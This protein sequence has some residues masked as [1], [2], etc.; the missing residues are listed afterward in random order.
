MKIRSFT[1]AAVALT[2]GLLCISAGCATK[3]PTAFESK[4]F[5]IQTN[6]VPVL[7]TQTNVVTQTNQVQQI[8]WQT[9]LVAGVPTPAPISTQMVVNVSWTT[10]VVTA[11]NLIAQYEYAPGTNAAAITQ[12]GGAI[13]NLFGVGGLVSTAL[14][15]LFGLWAG[16]RS[17]KNAKTAAA[18]A[19]IIETGRQLLATTPQGAALDEKWKTWMIQHQADA[20]VISQVSQIVA[21]VVDNETA[22]AAALQIAGLMKT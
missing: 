15:G 16:L 11:T 13:G 20:G 10:N 18:L 14:T 22:K 5:T 4:L 12:A 21:N 9:N 3:P 17:S 6:F 7:V 1:L 2:A 8:V 19:Q